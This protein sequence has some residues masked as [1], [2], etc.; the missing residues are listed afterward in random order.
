[1]SAKEVLII[2]DKDNVSDEQ[3]RRIEG[4]YAAVYTIGGYFLVDYPV[5]ANSMVRGMALTQGRLVGTIVA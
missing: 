2:P 3:Y 1:M 5:V 4:F